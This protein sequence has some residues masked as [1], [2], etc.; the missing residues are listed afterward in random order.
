MGNG[1]S[2]RGFVYSDD[3]ADA[4]VF[5]T[6]NY[7]DEQVINI[8]HGQDQTILELAEMVMEVVGFSGTIVTDPSKPDGTPQKLLDVSRLSALGWIPKVPLREGI[9]RTYRSYLESLTAQE[10][11]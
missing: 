7:S 8:G 2:R 9:E 5:L 11:E 10:L 3:L 1:D 6:E 4:A